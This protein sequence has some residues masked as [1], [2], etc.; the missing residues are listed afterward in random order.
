MIVDQLNT[1]F[2]QSAVAGFAVTAVA[3]QV[4]QVQE[5]IPRV[6]IDTSLFAATTVATFAIL[7]LRALN[8]VTSKHGERKARVAQIEQL[9]SDIPRDDPDTGLPRHRLF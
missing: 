4:T 2:T 6:I 7:Q 1:M 9:N 5:T 8:E 3:D